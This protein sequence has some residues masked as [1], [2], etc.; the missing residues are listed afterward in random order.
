MLLSYIEL[1]GLINERVITANRSLVNAA[2]IDLTLGSEVLVEGVPGCER[3]LRDGWISGSAPH[4]H[5]VPKIKVLSLRDRDKPEFTKV[6]I[7]KE[8]VILL[9]GQFM[10]AHSEQVFNLPDNISA[11]Y[12]E[13][14][15]M[16]R[17]GLNHLNAGWADAGWSGSVLTLELH[18]VLSHH[19]IELRAGDPAGQMI[20]FK[21]TK[22]PPEASYARRG[23]YNGDMTVEGIKP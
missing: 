13:K 2:S 17:I 20:F 11:I 3:T 8:P 21:H 18:N 1:M 7:S 5:I 9:P 16:A 14:S 4:T 19:A 12:A 22:V 23:R 15:S 10:L 6:D